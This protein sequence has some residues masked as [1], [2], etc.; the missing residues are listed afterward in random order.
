MKSQ[1]RASRAGSLILGTTLLGAGAVYAQQAPDPVRL[2]QITVTGSN[3]PTTET[4][5]DALAIPVTRIDQSVIDQSLS[6]SVGEL[7]QRIT[8]S[9]GGAIPISNN[10]TGFTPAASSVSLRGLGPE[11]TLVLINGRRVASYPIGAGGTSA[12]V[13]LN[14]IPADSI[15]SIEI[16]RDG[17]TAVYG[18]DAV[19][20]V[21]NIRLRN[22]YDGLGVSFR[23]AWST[24]GDYEE[25]AASLIVGAGNETTSLTAV[26]STFKNTP[27]FNRDR[28]YSALPPF[29]SGNS[30]PINL[31]GV[32][33]YVIADAIGAAPG[34]TSIPGGPG[35]SSTFSLT[36]LG[37]L[38]LTT[39]NVDAGT[40]QPIFGNQSANNNGTLPAT[41]YTVRNGLVDSV[42]FGAAS[43]FNF[44]EFSMSFPESKRNAASVAIEHQVTDN[45]S[46]YSD[47][48]VSEAYYRNELAPAATGSFFTPGRTQL[49]IPARTASPLP[50]VVA[51]TD[52]PAGTLPPLNQRTWITATEAGLP[53]NIAR[54]AIPRGV[55]PARDRIAP[56]GAFNPFNPFNEDLSGSTAFRT[57]EFGNRI[58][59]TT[60][61]AWLATV[62]IKAKE[63]FDKVTA[64]MGYRRS[65]IT[66]QGDDTVVSASRF[67]EIMNQ[68]SPLFQTGGQFAGQPAYNPFGYYRNPIASNF[69]LVEYASVRVKDR[70]ES[71]LDTAWLDLGAAELF[72]LP[73]G[74]VGASLGFDWRRENLTQSPDEISRTGDQIGSSPS[75]S[76][77]S[78]D[79]T[80][81]SVYAGV[82]IPLVSPEN[83]LPF[84]HAASIELA[85][86]YEE[87]FTSDRN[88]WSP[89]I[90]ARYLPI[91]EVA[92]RAS[93]GQGYREP[94]L[95]E[96]FGGTTQALQ[97][98]FNPRLG[99]TQQEVP[100]LRNGNPALEGEESTSAN[101]GVVWTPTWDL[102]KGL[103]IGVDAWRITR[104]DY[105]NL[106]SAADV[107]AAFESGNP[108]PFTNVE[109]DPSTNQIV[110]IERSFQ[111]VNE[112]EVQG[113]DFAITYEYPT[114]NFGKFT[115][116]LG[117]TWFDR[118]EFDGVNLVGQEAT[119]SSDDA[120]LR[121]KGQLNV[122]WQF[123][124]LDITVLNYWINGFQ[125]FAS[126][127]T[128]RNV[129]KTVL[130]DLYVSYDLKN[131]PFVASQEWLEGATGFVGV[132]NI[133][134]E[135]PPFASYFAVNS[136]GYPGF[137]YDARDT[138]VSIGMD[139]EF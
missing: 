29:L 84:A 69:P 126:D 136:T 31:A 92:L 17:G 8:I 134:G 114:D 123:E 7:L 78:A 54:S 95:Y 128:P 27:I 39:G 9:N 70:N 15:E 74:P 12:F 97:N 66:A 3:V 22:D 44:N 137:L 116:D 104:S 1:L 82:R 117:A 139:L 101:I 53:A 14:S 121:W 49:V 2:D 119:G 80:I 90:S 25:T 100:I 60:N 102:I 6:V 138:V 79:R 87:F 96:L 46:V 41:A 21:V 125:D 93:W 75:G 130:T 89:K 127:G 42:G 62:G 120:Y 133:F 99:V 58:Y 32:R 124:G 71:Q 118:Y 129:E 26:L 94:S 59:R 113:V 77:T 5:A 135:E 103:T 24:Q 131:I 48:M 122:G 108:L 81:G 132:R 86:R 67:N 107:I 28:E 56:L 50:Y 43:R 68:N 64:D 83:E 76:G 91:E 115:F 72:E 18:A 23:Q 109:F 63:L 10:A 45:I 30:S 98:I 40:G 33:R 36:T 111:N 65:S 110:I 55:D 112:F 16:L 88:T 51:D 105:V 57:A 38:N 85:L 20:G 13:D 35:N 37:T 19:A 11:A 47:L 52:V 106:P 4:A 73:T 34:A 61:T